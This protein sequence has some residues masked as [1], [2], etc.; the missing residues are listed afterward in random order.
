M[1]SENYKYLALYL[2]YSSPR[3][4]L[5]GEVFPVLTL[6]LPLEQCHSVLLQ[7]DDATH[8]L[9]QSVDD[10]TEREQ[11]LVDVLGLIEGQPH[12]IRLVHLE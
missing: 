12:G 2:D 9:C 8:P 4:L 1:F 7:C 6:I 5:C 3:R 11:R 10:I